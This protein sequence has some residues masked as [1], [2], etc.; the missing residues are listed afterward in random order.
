[1]AKNTTTTNKPKN[2]HG[3]NPLALFPKKTNYYPSP[4]IH[5]LFS[6]IFRKQVYG[7]PWEVVYTLGGYTYY[8]NV[9]SK[10]TV[11]EKPEEV[12]LEKSECGLVFWLMGS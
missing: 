9:L 4:S 12:D 7:T 3:S 5:N 8:H 6:S 10:E 2:Q 1:M 11:W